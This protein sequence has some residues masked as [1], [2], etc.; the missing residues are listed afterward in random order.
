MRWS[1]SRAHTCTLVQSGPVGTTLLH[2]GTHR[3]PGTRLYTHACAHTGSQST[4]L[5][6]RVHIRFLGPPDSHGKCTHG[7]PRHRTSHSH[8]CTHGHQTSHMCLH[9][10]AS[11]FH[12]HI[13]HTQAPDFTRVCTHR[14]WGTRLHIHVCTQTGSRGTR[15]HTHTRARTH[16]YGL[17]TQALSRGRDASLLRLLHA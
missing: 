9:T 15:L 12:T 11:R 2:T 4:R 7:I 3:F 13:V 1:L 8:V 17:G 16:T 6:T 14:L 5:Y 10:Q